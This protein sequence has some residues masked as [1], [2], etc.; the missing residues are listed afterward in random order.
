MNGRLESVGM[1]ISI[2]S[3]TSLIIKAFHWKDSFAIM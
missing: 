3:L 1:I 2:D